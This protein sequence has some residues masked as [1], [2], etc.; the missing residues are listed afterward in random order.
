VKLDF[1][2]IKKHPVMI[3]GGLVAVGVVVY[4]LASQGADGGGTSV[5]TQGPS[6]AEVALAGQSAQNQFQLAYLNAQVQGELA[7]RGID[8]AFQ[9]QQLT[10]QL[11]LASQNQ[12]LQ[13]QESERYY[14][15]QLAGLQANVNMQQSQ[16][17][18]TYQLAQLSSATSIANSQIAASM[19]AAITQAATQ[20]SL[21]QINATTTQAQ[22]YAR[23]QQNMA[24][25]AAGAA[26]TSS[27]LGFAST[28]IGAFF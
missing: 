25:A 18:N 10:A 19:Q 14:A 8:Y 13:Q 17:N 12:V 22:I 4:L 21:A 11:Q 27:W 9:Q 1:T 15:L 6:D 7:V 26:N 2:I 5:T 20:V 16:L 3:G 23:M 24:S 28:L